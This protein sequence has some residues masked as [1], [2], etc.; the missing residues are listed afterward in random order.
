MSSARLCSEGLALCGVLMLL[1]ACQADAPPRTGD[2]VG[3]HVR[4]IR[5]TDGAG[6]NGNGYGAVKVESWDTPGGRFRVH[7]TREG[8]HA[9]PTKDDNTNNVPDFVEG[10]GTTF[11]AVLDAYVK[12]GLR[13]PLSDELLHDR[14][15]Y[16]GDGKFDVYLQDQGKGADGYLVTEACKGVPPRCAGYMVVENDFVGYAYK[17]PEEGMQILASHEFF[18]AVQ[19]AYRQGLTQTFSEGTAVWGTELVYPE[20]KDFERFLPYFFKDVR[21]PLDDVPSSPSDTYSYATCIWP[22]FISERYGDKALPAV[23]LEL[24][25]QGKAPTA[26]DA[27]DTVLKRD[28][29]SSLA[30]AFA[31]FALWNLLTG[32]R[33]SAGK[34]YAEAAGYPQVTLEKETRPHPFRIVGDIAYLSARYIELSAKAGQRLTVTSERAEPKLVMHLVSGDWASPTIVSGKP[35]ETSLSIDTVGGKVVL[36]LASTARSGGKSLPVSVVVSG[37]AAPPASDAGVTGD[38]GQSGGGDDGGGCAVAHRDESTAGALAGVLLLLGLVSLRRRRRAVWTAAALTCLIAAVAFSAGCSDDSQAQDSGAKDAS[39]DANALDTGP[40]AETPLALGQIVDV[41]ADSSGVIQASVPLAGGEQLMLLLLSRDG[42]PLAQYEYSV[43]KTTSARL[44]SPVAKRAGDNGGHDHA[45]SQSARAHPCR[46]MREIAR[47]VDTARKPLWKLARSSRG[48][49]ANNPPKVGDTRSFDLRTSGTS[50][51]TITAEAL[52][53]DNVAVFWIDKTTTPL[54]TIEAATLKELGDNFAKVVIPRERQLFGQESDV[55]GDGLIHVLLSPLVNAGGAVAYVSPCDLIKAGT[56]PGCVTSNG[57]ELIYLSPP[58][59]LGPPYNTPKAMLETIAHEFQH[60]IYFYRKFILNKAEG[61]IENP[62]ITEGLS[63][64]AQ[65]LTGYQ[66]GNL[67]VQVATLQQIDLV[68]VPN[69]VDSK[70]SSYVPQ[71]GDG[72][73]RGAGYFLLRY[74]YDRAGGDAID[75]QGVIT[76]KGGIAW[77]RS[78]VDNDKTGLASALQSSKLSYEQLVEGF[79]TTM[80]LSNRVAGGKPV[81]QDPAHSFLPTSTDPATDR[82]RGCDLFASFHASQMVG[83]ATQE[84]SAA[85]GKLR[86]GGAELL[87]VKPAAGKDRYEVTLQTNPALKAKLRL[88]RIR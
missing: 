65:D 85:D 87:V 75:A 41:E 67:Y 77:L 86:P 45:A 82:Q 30:Q 18:H 81:S 15:D 20:T 49:F 60:S 73:M 13:E 68:S 36:V 48:T 2:P 78:F 52:R 56:I 10:F 57:M 29:Q 23:F 63:H 38:S 39:V 26:L 24:S 46:S 59:T 3:T 33:A 9:V 76:D 21:R 72:V 6:W 69:V 80:A 42:T 50:V 32:D 11:D 25:E 51:S 27:V 22:R 84:L 88:I 7:Y 19:N 4:E 70:I 17:S 71:P 83:P 28:Q 37:K 61:T 62:Y 16:G 47:V 12:A 53:V 5:P 66:A 55:D 54:A 35:G 14:P 34:G 64:L 58:E 44:S 31:E 79:W 43:V 74:L 1:G 8:K 40:D